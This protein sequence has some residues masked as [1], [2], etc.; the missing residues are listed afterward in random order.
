MSIW[1]HRFS[2]GIIFA[3]SVFNI[4]MFNSSFLKKA[5][6]SRMTIVTTLYIDYSLTR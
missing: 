5:A 4:W 2:L 3:K 1:S 6:Y